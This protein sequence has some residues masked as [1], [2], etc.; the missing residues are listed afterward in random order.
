MTTLDIAVAGQKIEEHPDDP[1]VILTESGI[2]YRVAE[3]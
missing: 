1:R 2:G 3:G